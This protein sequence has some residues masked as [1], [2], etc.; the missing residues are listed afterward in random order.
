MTT[1]RSII[2]GSGIVY[3]DQ[4]IKE[5]PKNVLAVRGPLTRNYLLNYGVN[6]PEIYGDPA[7]LFPKYYKPTVNKKYKLGIIPH[8]RDKNNKF[9][10]KYK[11]NNDVLIIDVTNIKP[12][13]KFIDDINSC[14]NIVSSSLH[15]II[16]SDAY[17]IP[18][19]WI[20]FDAGESKRFA[21]QDYLL[22]VNKHIDT[23]FI[24]NNNIDVDDLMEE[25]KKW[26]EPKIDLDLLLSVCP[27][28]TVKKHETII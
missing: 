10:E 1:S 12:W 6:C 26:T 18:N 22:S 20:E 11:N 15:G 17:G 27:F 16:I 28:K 4:A 24:I 25:C 2:W 23:P 8:F 7:L 21:F 5:K 14:Q 3:P 19:T 13:S 9:L